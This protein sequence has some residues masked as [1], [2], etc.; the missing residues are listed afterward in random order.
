[1]D[2]DAVEDLLKAQWDAFV[3][4]DDVSTAIEIRQLETPEWSE[5]YSTLLRIINDTEKKPST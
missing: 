2:V 1:M 3:D 4:R 5:N